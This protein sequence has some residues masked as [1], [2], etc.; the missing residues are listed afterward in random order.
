MPTH[1]TS[2]LLRILALL[3]FAYFPLD[4]YHPQ[5]TEPLSECFPNTP[6]GE[7]QITELKGGFS[8]VSIYKIE[9]EEKPYVLRILQSPQINEQ[10]TLELFCLKEASK[11]GIAPKVRY[12]SSNGKIILMDFVPQKT[13][14]MAQANLPDNVVRL[15]QAFRKA[16]QMKGHPSEGTSL[17]ANADMCFS[18]INLDFVPKEQVLHAYQLIQQYSQ[19]LANYQYEKVHVHADLNPR[20]IFITE[21][22][23][24]LIDWAETKLEDPFYD[25]TY[26]SLMLCYGKENEEM[27]LTSYLE[28][29]P[30]KEE[31]QR[32]ELRK[33]LHFAF[34][35][36]TDLYMAHMELKK[37]P[38]QQIDKNS[39]PKSWEFYQTAFSD[40]LEE[41]PA[42]YFYDLS[43]ICYQR[44]LPG[45]QRK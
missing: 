6:L 19:E 45:D 43:N 1:K 20:N 30:T 44:C 32:Y 8:G 22:Q 38:E 25:L 41:I 12:V 14:L 36:M 15:A 4:A 37:H 16:H 23:V 40:Y 3:Y 24:Y 28:R 29:P 35:T 11:I 2:F 17:L 10:N 39:I 21:D 34:W 31:R 13:L 33:K 5:L 27:F 9:A 26:F 7:V 18:V 42:Q